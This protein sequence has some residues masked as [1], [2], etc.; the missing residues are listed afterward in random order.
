MIRWRK[1]FGTVLETAAARKIPRFRDYHTARMVYEKYLIEHKDLLINFGGPTEAARTR[2]MDSDELA[3]VEASFISAL[4]GAE[5]VKDY[6]DA[7]VALQQLGQLYYY[8][9]RLEDSKTALLKSLEVLS[10]LVS[11]SKD[12]KTVLSD[13]HY[14]LGLTYI[15]LNMFAEAEKELKTSAAIDEANGNKYNLEYGQAAMARLEA[16]KKLAK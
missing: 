2:A 12:H 14:F 13:S 9:G 16:R 3:G 1:L 6:T 7:A 11:M 8:Q 5:N 4:E 15:D 10:G